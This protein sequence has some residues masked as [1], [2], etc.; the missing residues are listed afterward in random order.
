MRRRNTHWT[1]TLLAVFVVLVLAVPAG[2][3][4]ST[5]TV[6]G[7]V[8]DSTG[9]VPGARIVA[10]NVSS[11][12]RREAVT[13]VDGRYQLAGLQPGTYTI[14]VTAEAY[15]EQSR[16]VQLLL[17]QEASADFRL[18]VD[19]VYAETLTVVGEGTPVLVDM[20]SPEVSTNITQQQIESL[21]LNNR[22]FLAFA[23][24]LAHSGP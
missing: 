19:A 9:S 7:T 6:S 8:T 10:T 2:A 11:G 1:W 5:A 17:G 22:N 18:A 20:R 13:G 12:F 16:T 24:R 15:R 3:Q 14:T 4:I 23:G 21:P